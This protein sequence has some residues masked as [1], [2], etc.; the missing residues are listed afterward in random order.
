MPKKRGN[1]EIPNAS[2]TWDFR[3]LEY[4]ENVMNHDAQKDI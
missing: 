3:N 2:K 1:A 4:L